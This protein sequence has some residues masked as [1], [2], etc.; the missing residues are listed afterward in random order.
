MKR[1]A[2]VALLGMGV[3]LSED[4]V[5]IFSP[6]EGA[7]YASGV[8]R[9]VALAGADAKP[10]VDGKPVEAKS[11]HAGVLQAELRLAA[12][13]HE[14]TL[15][16]KKVRFSAGVPAGGEFKPFRDHP[17][18]QAGCDSCH[19]VR[20]GAWRFQRASLA[21][22]CGQCHEKEKFVAKHTH[23]MG[24][25]TDCQ[26]CHAPHGST[27]VAHLKLGREKACAQCHSLP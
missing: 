25:L 1:V 22:V 19:A 11:P 4:T 8:V 9:L 18:M 15:G 20:N 10:A 23:D 5:E 24:I 13:V 2:L 21:S 6:V 12:G 26:M 27:A 16:D 14:L 17:P 7:A 3:A